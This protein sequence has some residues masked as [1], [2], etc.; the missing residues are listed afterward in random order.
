MWYAGVMEE[1]R[2]WGCGYEDGGEIGYLCLVSREEVE[3]LGEV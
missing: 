1:V 2:V 3:V